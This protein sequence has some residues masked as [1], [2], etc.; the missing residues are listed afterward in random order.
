MINSEFMSMRKS[1]IQESSNDLLR[2]KTTKD[3]LDISDVKDGL[4]DTNIKLLN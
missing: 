4:N 3:E 1:T 2:L